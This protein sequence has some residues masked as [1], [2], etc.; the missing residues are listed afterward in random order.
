MSRTAVYRKVL[1]ERMW[2][3]MAVARAR[4]RILKIRRS[5]TKMAQFRRVIHTSVTEMTLILRGIALCTMKLVMYG[6]NLG[7]ARSHS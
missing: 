7:W 3:V 6:P 5:A 2:M 4:K 1:Y